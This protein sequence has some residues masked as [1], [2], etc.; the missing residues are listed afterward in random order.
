MAEDVRIGREKVKRILIRS[1]NW[2]GDAVMSLP[3]VASVRLTFPEAE[4][5]LLAKLAGVKRATV[6]TWVIHQRQRAAA[7][8]AER[9]ELLGGPDFFRVAVNSSGVV[10]PLEEVACG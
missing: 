10:C 6:C 2:V 7:I 4:I 9:L 3:A 1:A 8:Q 5:T